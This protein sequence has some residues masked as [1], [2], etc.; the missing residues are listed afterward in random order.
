MQLLEQDKHY[1]K[2]LLFLAWEDEHSFPV[3][4]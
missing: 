3:K 1:H 2:I 4:L